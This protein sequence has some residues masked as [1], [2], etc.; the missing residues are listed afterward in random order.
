MIFCWVG[1][2]DASFTGIFLSSRFLQKISVKAYF[3]RYRL[4]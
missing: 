4:P 2:A 1:F 3:C